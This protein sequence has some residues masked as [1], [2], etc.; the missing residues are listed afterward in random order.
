[1]WVDLNSKV[2]IRL[3]LIDANQNWVSDHFK[4]GL[5]FKIDENLKVDHISRKDETFTEIHQQS[6]SRSKFKW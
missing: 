3:T 4:K 6:K 5:R 1:M 2:D